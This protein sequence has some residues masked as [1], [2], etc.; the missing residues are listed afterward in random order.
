M[1]LTIETWQAGNEEHLKA[2]ADINSEWLNEFF[3]IEETDAAMFADPQGYIIDK[4]GIILFA[5]EGDELLGTVCLFQIGDG[6]FE[7]G[8]MGVRGNTRGKGIGRILATEAISWARR[9]GIPKLY[10]ASNHKLAQAIGL[11]KSLGFIELP[12]NNDARYA[13]CDITLEMDLSPK[14]VGGRKGPDP[15]RY[16]D[17][18][19]AGKCVDF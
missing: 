12:E 4:G 18:E 19:N 15:V 13:R 10:I 16:G 17:W 7:L 3:R 11:Y 6:V 5:R 2:F 1:N 14:E 9:K 8:K